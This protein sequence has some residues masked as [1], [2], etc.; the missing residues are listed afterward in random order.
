MCRRRRRRRRVTVSSVCEHFADPFA[1]RAFRFDG[2]RL[3]EDECGRGHIGRRIWGRGVDGRGGGCPPRVERA[4]TAAAAAAAVRGVRSRRQRH[5]EWRTFDA[6]RRGRRVLLLLL[7]ALAPAAEQRDV[8]GAR[9]T[10]ILRVTQAIR[11]V[12]KRRE[13]LANVVAD[14]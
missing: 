5:G 2:V 14:E 6:G 7:L 3:L 8:L 1:A 13:Q 10:A 9:Y 4:A 12:A 11:A